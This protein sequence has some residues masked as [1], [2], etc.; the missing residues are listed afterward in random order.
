MNEHSLKTAASWLI[1][2]LIIMQ[3]IPLNRIN[4]PENNL[5][6]MLSFLWVRNQSWPFNETQ[7]GANPAD[8]LRQA[9]GQALLIISSFARASCGGS[10]GLF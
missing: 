10:H 4:P 8:A 5:F 9:E 3:F 2:T 6:I 1:L 7:Q